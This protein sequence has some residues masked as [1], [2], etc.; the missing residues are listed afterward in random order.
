MGVWE[1][2]EEVVGHIDLILVSLGGKG[3]LLGGL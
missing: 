2:D 3:V 1:A